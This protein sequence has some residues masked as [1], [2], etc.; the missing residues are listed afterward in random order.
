VCKEN[1]TTLPSAALFIIRFHSFYPMHKAGAYTHLMNEE[2][3]KNLE[4]L[5]KFKQYDNFP[6]VREQS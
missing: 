1:G 5:K 2:D 4:W 3:R 6:H